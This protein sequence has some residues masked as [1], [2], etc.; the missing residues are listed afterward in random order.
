MVLV[1]LGSGHLLVQLIVIGGRKPGYDPFRHTISELG[2]SGSPEERRVAF[3]VF[4]P[5]GLLVLLASLLLRSVEPRASLLAGCIAAGYLVAAIFPCDPGSPP[6]GSPRQAL[7]NIGGAVEY[8]GGSLALFQLSETFG[9]PF[10]L[11]GFLVLGG[12]VALSLPR[13]VGVGLLQRVMEGSLF[14]GLL[15]AIWVV[16]ASFAG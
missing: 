12:A 4:L 6:L 1:L 8:L 7:H 2:E 10:R 14:A 11:A 13:I 15:L 3:G 5:V 16:R 9:Q